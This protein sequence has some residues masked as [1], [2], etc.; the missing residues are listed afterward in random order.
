VTQPT[1][2]SG[3]ELAQLL[4]GSTSVD[5]LLL[6]LLDDASRSALMRCAVVR[7]FG[8][9]LYDDV[10]RGADGPTLEDLVGH[11]HVVAS[12]EAS[13]ER[14][15]R[16]GQL[17]DAA[18]LSFWVAEGRAPVVVAPVP[19]RLR[20]VAAECAEWLA[21]RDRSLDR[22]DALLQSDVE[23]AERL[24]AQLFEAADRVHDLAGCHDVLDVL[25]RRDR[26]PLYAGTS[27]AT[28]QLRCRA[29]LAARTRWAGDYSASAQYFP[30]PALERRLERLLRG[31]STRVLQLFARGGMGKTMQLRWFLG[32]RC[33]AGPEH[34]PCAGIDFDRE[35]PGRATRHP[36]L[37]ALRIAEQL[38]PQLVGDQ[39]RALLESHGALVSLLYAAKRG[40]P[41]AS[42][43]P[44]PYDVDGKDVVGRITAVLSERAADRPVVVVVD[45]CEELLRPGIEP[46]DLLDLLAGLVRRI[47]ALRLVLAGRYDLA[48]SD[49]LRSRG[50]DVGRLFPDLD[51]CRVPAFSRADR[52][53]Y[54]VDV[55]HLPDG[56]LVDVIVARTR[57][58]PFH[59][60]TFADLARLDRDITA[61]ELRTTEDP[62]LLYCIERILK[63]VEPDVR[64]LLRYGVV[65]RRLSVTFLREVMRPFLVE[66]MLEAGTGRG[67]SGAEGLPLPVMS[68]PQTDADISALW[69]RMQ[70]YAA[71]Y[72]WVWTDD[73]GDLRFH[74]DVLDP[75]RAVARRAPFYRP[76]HSAAVRHFERLA[77]TD[78]ERWATWTAE[79]LYHRFQLDGPKASSRWYDALALARARGVDE[80]V[81]TIAGEPLRR[82]YLDEDGELRR[83]RRRTPIIT[84][85][86]VVAAHVHLALAAADR[87]ARVAPVPVAGR[88]TAP[89]SHWTEAQRHLRAAR[90]IA[91]GHGV[92]M[93]Q[94]ETDLVEARAAL[95]TGRV[96][97]AADVILSGHSDLS[98]RSLRPAIELTQRLVRHLQGDG[99]AWS[100]F[101]ESWTRE[102]TGD[103]PGVG[104]QAALSRAVAAT[105]RGQFGTALH[106]LGRAREADASQ[107]DDRRMSMHA[108]ALIAAG[109]PSAA[110]TLVDGTRQ[111][112]S[113]LALV[114]AHLAAD[115]PLA[116][117]TVAD[118]AM[119]SQ[120]SSTDGESHSTLCRLHAAAQ[121]ELLHVDDA[122]TDL[123]L[124]R[125]T[126]RSFH[127]PDAEAMAAS[128]MCLLQLRRIGDRRNAAAC[129]EDAWDTATTEG[130]VGWLAAHL[131]RAELQI[132][133]GDQD[134]ARGTLAR[135]RQGLTS[136]AAAVHV[137]VVE[138][139]AGEDHLG[140]A[141]PGLVEELRAIDPPASR[142]MLLRDLVQVPSIRADATALEALRAAVGDAVPPIGAPDHA[143]LAWRCAEAERVRGDGE[144]ARRLLVA[145]VVPA[146]TDNPF[147]WWRAIEGLWRLGRAGTDDP[148]PPEDPFLGMGEVPGLR[149]AWLL[150]VVQW[151]GHLESTAWCRER[152]DVAETLLLRPQ[153]L[154]TQWRAELEET[155][156]LVD[157]R[158]GST[159]EA[160]RAAATASVTWGRLGQT[161]RRAEIA[162]AY[163]LGV[164]ADAGADPD[165]ELRLWLGAGHPDRAAV[166][167]ALTVAGASRSEQVV[168]RRLLLPG[169]SDARGRDS[170]ERLRAASALV[171]DGWGR[172]ADGMGGWMSSAGLDESTVDSSGD[173]RLVFGHPELAAL[174]WELTSHRGGG[175]LALPHA[176]HPRRV[177]RCAAA[178]SRRQHEVA[179][180]QSALQ[181]LGFFTR[182]VDGL[183]G[184]A[185]RAAVADFQRSSGLS[186]GG[187]LSPATWQRLRGE[188][189]GSARGRP[190]RVLVVGPG[191]DAG[192]GAADLSTVV[193]LTALYASRGAR[194]RTVD[195][196]DLLRRGHRLDRVAAERPHVIHVLATV[197]LVGGAVV[198]DTGATPSRDRRVG[199][200]LD[201]LSMTALG[202]FLATASGGRFG[203]AVIVETPWRPSRA[204]SARSLLLRNVL[205]HHLL[206]LGQIEAVL[207]TGGGSP[208]RQ[209]RHRETVVDAVATGS[210]LGQVAARV[211][212]SAP[213]DCD[214]EDAVSRLG[215]ALFVQRSLRTLLPIGVE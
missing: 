15:Y 165:L 197:D 50:C 36:W 77:S 81:R 83:F 14:D 212:T 66:G 168:E 104:L 76:L 180:A 82:E 206:G 3:E 12:G 33:A 98:G 9:E 80:A 73:E 157:Q 10:L 146:A 167:A 49:A 111:P 4:E 13:G 174:P 200:G 55:R 74:P 126:A 1:S 172:W 119:A 70:N 141:L 59:L 54:L 58:S 131:A 37:V 20:A 90:E 156:A 136:A 8:Q 113:R 159:D 44:T 198:V 38:E 195:L 144:A 127:D 86:V 213:P 191:T 142:L 43:L 47:P 170:G 129:L 112:L 204:E 202:D 149:A 125:A 143:M 210:D 183:L 209:H 124:A 196:S 53:R 97:H 79:A 151:R 95:A 21:H 71:R 46:G 140:Q 45:T 150:R 109:S 51:S 193:E 128:Q 72:S 118:D 182:R 69:E 211:Q 19:D 115:R 56:E 122:L 78:D 89:A 190:L 11:G 48:V 160:R 34:I 22:L 87:A 29:R 203:P 61:E 103:Q 68:P 41:S 130:S 181:S 158:A 185:T 28:R 114:R 94:P 117:L 6:H 96:G 148:E 194:V 23:A 166:H 105:D 62:G 169:E 179:A 208:A 40:A 60:A 201:Q 35:D 135:C 121:A 153:T 139:I 145:H 138:L 39:F 110:A 164:V 18:Y 32:R 16:V 188:L 133:T 27:L 162:E 64:W 163:E 205:G 132:R 67:R 93:P 189:S 186:D 155:R 184:A 30:R 24:M 91:A 173:L 102:V 116:A 177:Y 199:F 137:S 88:G 2:L 120:P 31:G 215:S 57:R 101:E 108:K 92:A 25:E 7:Q 99:D 161:G 154:P 17:G 75:L 85:D 5:T 26:I 147:L 63:R 42:P 175:G 107:A 187:D 100:G 106:W 214:L 123:H 52:R 207:C 84:W 176:F 152:L 65:P 178:D 192:S 134:A 171:A